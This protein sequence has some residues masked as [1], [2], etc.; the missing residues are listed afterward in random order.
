MGGSGKRI[1]NFDT[2][3]VIS[4]VL[5]ATPVRFI[6]IGNILSHHFCDSAVCCPAESNGSRP[7]AAVEKSPADTVDCLVHRQQA[8][9]QKQDQDGLVG[10]CVFSYDR[11][12][13]CLV[14][15]HRTLFP[16]EDQV[17]FGFKLPYQRRR[18]QPATLMMDKEFQNETI[19]MLRFDANRGMMK[20]SKQDGR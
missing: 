5:D 20:V 3:E 17:Q 18:F 6:F 14:Y 11:L 16:G 1:H 13:V 12:L 8:C 7:L 4:A 19:G 9:C 10:Y 15:H 2:K